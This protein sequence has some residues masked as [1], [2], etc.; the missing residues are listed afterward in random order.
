ML[1]VLFLV[2]TA[3][4]W[5]CAAAVICWR[6]NP[7]GGRQLHPTVFKH[8]SDAIKELAKLDK[9]YAPIAFSRRPGVGYQVP[10]RW[11]SRSCFIDL[12]MHSDDDEDSV[13]FMDIAIE[14]GTLAAACVAQP[15]HLG[16][17]SFVGPKQVMNIT[18]LGLAPK[19]V[20]LPVTG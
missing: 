7:P 15:P 6:Q 14:A 8:C 19:R 5:T 9:A 2:I 11:V 16:G 12:D 4:H 20:H 3:I 10:Q 17:T 18:I 1:F 13:S